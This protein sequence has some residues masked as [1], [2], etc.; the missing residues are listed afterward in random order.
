V[1]V[2]AA[3]EEFAENAMLQAARGGASMVGRDSGLCRLI[4]LEMGY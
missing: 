1:V 4:D 3:S 2:P